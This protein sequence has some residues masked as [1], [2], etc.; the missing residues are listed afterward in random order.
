MIKPVSISIQYL[1]ERLFTED[2]IYELWEDQLEPDI[3]PFTLTLNSVKITYTFDSI[4]QTLKDLYR[5]L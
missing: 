4:K 3:A 1:I 5:I 2:G